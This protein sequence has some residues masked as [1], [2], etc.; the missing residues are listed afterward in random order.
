M[1]TSNERTMLDLLDRADALLNIASPECAATTRSDIR[2]WK[3]RYLGLLDA[4]IAASSSDETDGSLRR[5]A[6]WAAGAACDDE[7]APRMVK[8]IAAIAKDAL[9]GNADIAGYPSGISL[10]VEPECQHDLLKPNTTIEVIDKW[11]AKCT[12]CIEFFDLP[13]RPEKASAFQVC[14]APTEGHSK[15]TCTKPKGHTDHH[16]FPNMWND[17]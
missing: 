4:R 8:H 12:I 3:D 14:G 16:W 17:M 1:P 13:G 5:F 11:K 7:Y 2:M 6:E 9:A 10:S 15:G